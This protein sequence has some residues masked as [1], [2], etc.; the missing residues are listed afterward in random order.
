MDDG[1][2]ASMHGRTI[3]GALPTRRV[4]VAAARAAQIGNAALRSGKKVKWDGK[5]QKLAFAE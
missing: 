5:Q 4:G 1:D 3:L 2:L